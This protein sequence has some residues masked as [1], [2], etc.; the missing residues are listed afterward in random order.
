MPPVVVTADRTGDPAPGASRRGEPDLAPQRAATSDTAQL[1]QD[2]P[3]V[4]LYGAGGISSLPVIHGLADDRLRT[5]VDGMDLMT[6]CPNHMN[7]AL[8]FIDPS[9]VVSVE[10]FAGITP[11]SLGGDSIGG[12]IQVKSAPPKFAKADQDFLAEGQAGTFYRS[13]GNARGNNFGATLA[14][15]HVNVSY[16]ESNSESNN[17]RAAGDFKKPGAWQTMGERTLADNEVGSSEYGGS[18]NRRLGLALGLADHLLELTVSEQ[19]LNYE[20]FPN[21]RMDMIASSPDPAD[22]STYVVNKDKPS[23]VNKLLNLAYTGQYQWG[24]LE[25]RVFHQDLKHHMDMIQDR[26]YGMLMPMDTEATTLGGLL[27]GNIELSATDTLRLGSDF[28]NYRL[29]DWWPPLGPTPGSMSGDNFWNIRDGRRDRLGFFAEW[30]AQ[31]SPRWLTQVGIRSDTVTSDAG[32]AQG[33]APGFGNYGAD[34]AK[35]N[36]REHRRQD[37]NFDWTL[38]SRYTADAMQT[39]EAG[40]ARKTRSPNLYERYPWS[41]FSMAAL[42]NNFVGDGNAYIGNLD[43]KPEVA[44]TFSGTADWHAADKATWGFKATGYLTYVEDFIDARRCNLSGCGGAANLTKSNA[45]VSLQYVNQSARL[46]GFDLSAYSLLGRTDYFGS[47]T[48]TGALNYVRGKNRTTDDNLYHMMPLNTKLALVNRLG[49]WTSTA[50]FQWVDA[51]DHVSQ[52]RNEAQTKAYSLL[53]L[54][55]SYEWKYVRIDIGLENALNKFYLLP[56]GGA[57]LGQ[58]NSMT[59][60]GV[61]W[62]MSVP[63]RGRSLNLALNLKF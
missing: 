28:Q 13:N 38:L 12:T 60:N 41:A 47:F 56:L 5:Q 40:L 21:Q 46:Y 63:G 45:Y 9:S 26:F 1:L 39:Y 43:L 42:M 30:E 24:Q 62:G 20:G 48:L 50:E 52:V 59:T 6:A 31:W 18:R 37:H 22:P 4:S 36:A 3:G 25:A 8:S 7:S 16:T 55:S 15:Q 14:G 49:G 53:N 2:I 61:P 32:S 10:V 35:F 51:K 23:N 27:K 34:S 57:Y 58:G 17:Y 44:H 19:R 11:V 29:N 54:R 33:Y